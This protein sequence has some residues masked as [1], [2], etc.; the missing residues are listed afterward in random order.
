MADKTLKEIAKKMANLDIALLTTHTSRGQLSSRPMSNNGDV[1]YDGNSHYFTFEESR[2]VKD[3]TENAH[4]NL[5]FTGAKGLYVSIV[6]TAHLIRQKST[7]EE[8]WL[9]SLNQWFPQGIDTPGVVLVRVEAKRI[10][11]WQGEEEGELTVK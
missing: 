11:Y 5:G 2:T 7:M 6:G 3:I 8:H 10:K 1:T 9:P 4:V